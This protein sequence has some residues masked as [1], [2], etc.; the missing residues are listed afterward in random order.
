MTWSAV[1]W[2]RA[3]LKFLMSTDW[4][5]PLVIISDRDKKFLSELWQA[6][7][8]LLM[9]ALY[10]TIAY[11]LQADGQL[12]QTNQTVELMIQH[13]SQEDAMVDW[14]DKLLMV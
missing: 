7:F 3:L 1:D 6:M 12:E 11:H 5:F 14:E 9:V 2:V 10:F 13:I 8:T 4:G